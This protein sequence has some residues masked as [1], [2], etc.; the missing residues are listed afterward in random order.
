MYV[1]NVNTPLLF[2]HGDK[3]DAFGWQVAAEMFAALRR[4]SKRTEFAL[5]RGEG[6][7]PHDWSSGN[8]IDLRNRILNWFNLYLGR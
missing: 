5:Y 1:A 2:I 8:R 6:H 7:I 4:L 3:D